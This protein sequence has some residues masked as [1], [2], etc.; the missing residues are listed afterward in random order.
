VRASV[1]AWS[2]R[3]R[4]HALLS[5]GVEL[6]EGEEELEVWG[7]ESVRWGRSVESPQDNSRR[8]QAMS[9]AR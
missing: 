8:A 2:W 5:I 7:T 1:S 9:T 3:W 4:A 6:G